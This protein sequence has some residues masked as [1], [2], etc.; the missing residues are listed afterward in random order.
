[1][2]KIKIQK[3]NESHEG[4]S[5]NYMFFAN[6]GHVCRMASE[7]MCM[8]KGD[9]DEILKEH[10][11]AN[12]HLSKSMESIQH[13]YN[14]LL[15]CEKGENPEVPEECRD[16]QH[17]DMHS[18]DTQGHDTHSGE[19]H[20]DEMH[21]EQEIVSEKIIKTFES[22]KSHKKRD[23]KIHESND[24]HFK[25]GDFVEIISDN[26]NYTEFLDKKLVVTHIAYNTDQ[27][28]GYD[29]SVSPQALM[30]FETVDGE[31]VPFSLYEYEVSG[32]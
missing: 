20:D 24:G 8:D 31:E 2:K 14:F 32:V 18:D 11:W 30:D 5:E 1:M 21:S 4:K 28:P 15:A 26:E 27:H 7:M 6:L 25:K 23:I 13:V 17:H 29:E 10:D 19:M 16:T 9:V 22:W 3:F 12:D